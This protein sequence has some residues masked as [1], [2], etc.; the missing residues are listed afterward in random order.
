[1]LSFGAFAILAAGGMELQI[2][3]SLDTPARSA[4]GGMM[5][6]LIAIFV[7]VAALVVWAVFIRKSPRRRE[8]G[9]IVAP[10]PKVSE[11]KDEDDE[12]DGDGSHRRRRRR[13][14]RSRNRNPTLADTG[15][16]PPLGAGDPKSPPL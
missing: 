3:T 7:I 10:K 6:V 5:P 4:L 8:R 12:G 16:L 9:R 2:P 15:G 14:S 1:M 13:R 11:D